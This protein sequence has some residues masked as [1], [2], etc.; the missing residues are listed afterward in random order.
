MAEEKLNGLGWTA[1]S[2]EWRR[3]GCCL[4]AY[5]YSVWCTVAAPILPVAALLVYT[6]LLTKS[7]GNC[8]LL[9]ISSPI[10]GLSVCKSVFC[11]SSTA[12][13][14]CSTDCCFWRTNNVLAELLGWLVYLLGGRS[15]SNSPS[16]FLCYGCLTIFC[17]FGV[18]GRGGV[19]G[20]LANQSGFCRCLIQMLITLLQFQFKM[21]LFASLDEWINE[22]KTDSYSCCKAV[23]GKI[24]YEGKW[25]VF[26]T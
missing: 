1:I 20:T 10:Y 26:R 11:T 18:G 19:E 8:P 23:V 16:F 6:V 15:T 12:L 2:L 22:W 25:Y 5:M 4:Q 17:N 9:V 13:L 24:H 7:K 14:I 21:L 3:M